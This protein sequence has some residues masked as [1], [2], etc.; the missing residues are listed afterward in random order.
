M[1]TVDKQTNQDITINTLD[2]TTIG[3]MWAVDRDPY[4]PTSLPVATSFLTVGK[5]DITTKVT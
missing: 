4:S 3:H 5:H 2:N 1:T